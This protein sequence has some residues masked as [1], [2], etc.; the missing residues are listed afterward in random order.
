MNIDLNNKVAI[1]TGSIQGIGLEIAKTLAES[2]AAV[3]INNNREKEKLESAAR[4]MRDKGA[5]VKAVIADI[6]KKDEARKLIDAAIELG[7]IDILIN[8]AGGLVKRVPVADFD[9]EHF[10]TVMDINLKTAF[11]MANLVIPYMKEKK[12]GKIIKLSSQAAHDG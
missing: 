9:G 12:S 8:N 5:Q 1:V 3:V 10:Q 7:G 2:G 4:K 6:T 11:L